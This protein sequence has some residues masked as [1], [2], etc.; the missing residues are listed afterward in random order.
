MA[1]L[2]V[3]LLILLLLFAWLVRRIFGS[4][5]SGVKKSRQ[6]RLSVTDAA[7]VDDRRRLVLVRRD[8]VEHLVMIGGPSD[9]VIEQSIRR[10]SPVSVTPLQRQEDVPSSSAPVEPQ[11]KQSIAPAVGAAVAGTAA[12]DSPAVS[13]TASAATSNVAEASK[14][15]VEKATQTAS[16]TA[17]KAKDVVADAKEAVSEKV[18]DTKEAMESAIDNITSEAPSL[19][20]EKSAADDDMQKLLDELANE[21]KI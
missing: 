16:A 12:T 21:K 13:S 17:S 11:P 10:L 18:A 4:K 6:P 14:F 9:I 19:A 3:G 15:A 1:I 5:I 2:F 7:I 20:T 8:D